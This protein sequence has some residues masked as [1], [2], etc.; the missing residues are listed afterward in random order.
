MTEEKSFEYPLYADTSMFGPGGEMTPSAYQ[1][2]VTETV[3]RHLS[4]INM[5][6]PFLMKN[7]GI[8]WVL[9]SVSVK[10]LKPII[11]G[12]EPL[13]A[14]TWNSSLKPP[15][16]RRELVIRN[17][18]GDTYAKAV[19]FSSLFD[20]SSRR[21]CTD[22]TLYAKFHL[23]AGETLFDA[24][25]RPGKESSEF[26]GAGSFSVCASCADSLGHVNNNRYGDFAYDAL[27]AEKQALMP[28][29]HR[30]DI[31]F[32]H[33]LK[34][35]DEVSTERSEK[36]DSALIRGTVMPAEKVSF[37]AAFEFEGN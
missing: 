26:T 25:F 2:T 21:I 18:S 19:T 1:R 3:E 24:D 6:V 36:E 7:Y 32:L 12:G 8:S 5:D 33:E 4:N 29:L 35:G 34:P 16:Y 27:S 22:S 14:K 11:P 31:W 20:L 30:F 10:I 9:L 28:R 13:F 37:I 23:P 17:K 15:I